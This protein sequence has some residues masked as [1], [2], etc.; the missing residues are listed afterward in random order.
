MEYNLTR[1]RRKTL[2]IYITENA[3]LDVRAPLKMSVKDIESFLRLKESWINAH[4][5]AKQEKNRLQNEFVLDYGSKL[6]LL[7]AEYPIEQRNGS[8]CGFDGTVFYMPGGFDGNAIKENAVKIYKLLAK[9]YIAAKVSAYSDAVGVTPCSVKI[10]S[11][12][13]RW[14]SCSGRNSLNFSW[15]LMMAS[16]A[17]VDYV[18]VH[19]LSHILYHDHSNGFWTQ[20]ASVMPDY[21]ECQKQLKAVQC[22]LST[23]NWE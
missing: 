17:A 10:N 7:G 3:Q 16:E 8:R 14:G 2:A 22:R 9:K 5:A 11:A 12:K 18:V 15:R 23:E 20:V 13:T 6:L 4:I 21:K 19:E 1:S